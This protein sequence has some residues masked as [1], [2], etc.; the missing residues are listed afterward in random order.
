MRI[1]TIQFAYIENDY[2]KIK[3]ANSILKS[4]ADRFLRF[5]AWHGKYISTGSCRLCKPCKCRMNQPCAHPE[6]M[7]YSFES[8]GVDVGALIHEYF[9]KPLLWYKPG[10]LPEYTSVVC[11][12]LTN[13]LL[14]PEMLSHEYLKIITE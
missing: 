12:L 4:R 1:N 2:L 6:T 5:M 7:T 9:S 8:L 10:C 11:G 14:D 3:A 13:D